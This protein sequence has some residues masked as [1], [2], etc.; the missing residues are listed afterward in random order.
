MPMVCQ[1]PQSRHNPN[2]SRPTYPNYFDE[3]VLETAKG[4][5]VGLSERAAYRDGFRR[6]MTFFASCAVSRRQ[7]NSENTGE[8]DELGPARPKLISTNPVNIP[9]NSRIVPSL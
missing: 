6:Q 3:S 2:V 1:R 4:R 9:L 8:F 7:R 5:T